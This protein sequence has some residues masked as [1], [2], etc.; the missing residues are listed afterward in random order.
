MI[1]KQHEKQLGIF[2]MRHDTVRSIPLKMNDKI[3]NRL[4]HKLNT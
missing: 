3:L 1:F 4:K 2:L